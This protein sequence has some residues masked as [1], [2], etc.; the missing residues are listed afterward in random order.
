M[1]KKRAGPLPWLAY[2]KKGG[3][4]TN[5]QELIDEV[6]AKYDGSVTVVTNKSEYEIMDGSNFVGGFEGTYMCEL[7]G[8]IYYDQLPAITGALY[9]YITKG[10][11]EEILAIENR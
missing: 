9:D 1:T 7:L 11:K 4:E 8:N 3:G 5:K 6:A 10:I 2:A